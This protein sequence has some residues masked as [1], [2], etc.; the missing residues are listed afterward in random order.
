M[1]RGSIRVTVLIETIPAAFQMDEILY[2]LRDHI[3]GL[4]CGRWDY[5]F[6]FIKRFSSR[7]DFVL[8]DR[9]DVTMTSHFLRSY[10]QLLIK[11]CHRRGAHAMG[12]MAAQI[13]V[14]NDDAANRTAL[15]KVIA[16]KTREASDGHD[17]TWVAHPALV[18]LAREVFDQYMP[19]ANQTNKLLDD[20][21]VTAAD[22]LTVPK[23]DVTED[24]LRRN[25][26]VGLLYLSAWLSGN[27]CVPIHHLMEDA[28]TAEIS[29]TQLWQWRRHKVKMKDGR[30][31]D[32]ALMEKFLSEEA[33]K[34]AR[35]DRYFADA[36]RVFRD[37]VMADA[38]EEFL[39][40][41]AYDRVLE[42][43]RQA[44]EKSLSAG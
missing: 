41:K 42:Y 28:A 13:P 18:S 23:G 43:E 16:D 19:E 25:I 27:G 26:S 29:R 17:G 30:I 20:V 8:P 22:L 4:N 9:G 44:P 6:N 21:H 12:G 32:D 14:K 11:T 3:A 36:V 38:L 37:L 35:N 40:T 7:P 31:I 33:A 39:T 10:S 1:P 34:L 2:E 5:I 24:G 15:A